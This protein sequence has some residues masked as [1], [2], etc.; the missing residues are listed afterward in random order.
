[1]ADI[2]QHFQEAH[3]RVLAVAAVQE[4][5]QPAPYGEPI[6][7]GPYLSRLCESLAASMIPEGQSVSIRVEADAGTMSSGE[8]VSMGLITTELVINALKHAFP[9]GGSGAIIVRYESTPAS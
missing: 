7:A 3:E 5:L 6:A 4:H 1:S 2:R 8:A 9:T